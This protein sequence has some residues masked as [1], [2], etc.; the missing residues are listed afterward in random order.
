MKRTIEQIKKDID[1]WECYLD[2][3]IDR[4]ESSID[5]MS[6]LNGLYRELEEAKNLTQDKK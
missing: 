5:E 1:T 2:R 3:R 4:Q 6:H